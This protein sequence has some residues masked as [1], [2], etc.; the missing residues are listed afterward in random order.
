[1]RKAPIASPFLDLGQ[2]ELTTEKDGF[3]AT[4]REGIFLEIDREAVV[5]LTL[6][7]GDLTETIVVTG[8]APTIEAA[9]SALTSIVDSNTI[10]DLP[11][12]GRDYVQLA[13]LPGGRAH[14]FGRSFAT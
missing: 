10:A 3:K 14:R 8:R 11:L 12:N 4:Q 2:Y 6:E 13:T 1:M 9:P 7:V 5:N